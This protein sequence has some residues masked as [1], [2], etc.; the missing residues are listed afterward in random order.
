MHKCVYCGKKSSLRTCLC[1][2]VCACKFVCVC[3]YAVLSTKFPTLKFKKY[4]SI[5][6]FFVL[7]LTK[8]YIWYC[9]PEVK[10]FYW[11]MWWLK[12]AHFKKALN[13]ILDPLT[14]LPSV[15][16]LFILDIYQWNS[17]IKE[18]KSVS[19]FWNYEYI[20]LWDQER[21]SL[22]MTFFRTRISFFSKIDQPPRGLN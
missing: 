4:K 15:P 1:T 20:S 21:A 22:L 13:T 16:L 12:E 18:K 14:L 7:L 5:R 2:K 11:L 10:Q 19:R 9:L 6:I 8:T 3:M 17:I